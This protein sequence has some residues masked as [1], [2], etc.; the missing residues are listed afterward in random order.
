MCWF[1]SIERL[2]PDAPRESFLTCDGA[3]DG[4][5]PIRSLGTAQ[6]LPNS[7]AILPNREPV[8]PNWN[9]L[10]PTGNPLCPILPDPKR[11]KSCIYSK[12]SIPDPLFSRFSV[13]FIVISP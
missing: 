11:D 4:I 6:I 2:S 9:L 5:R 12:L 1:P 13:L 8:L 7:E 3:Q 10:C